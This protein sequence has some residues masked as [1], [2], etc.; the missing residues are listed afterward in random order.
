M[1]KF[2]IFVLGFALGSITRRIKKP[3]GQYEN[4]LLEVLDEVEE[5]TNTSVNISEQEKPF[6]IEDKKE[7][8]Y[9]PKKQHEIEV[10]E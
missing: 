3:K 4:N 2:I 10:V 6:I 8:M 5:S 9:S 1:I 7:D